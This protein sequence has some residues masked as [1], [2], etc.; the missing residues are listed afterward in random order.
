MST[1]YVER[2]DDLV[3]VTATAY[4]S[5]GVLQALLARHPRLISGDRG[6]EEQRWLL[7]RREA[8]LASSQDGGARWSVDHLFLDRTAVPTLV[9][10]KRSTDTRIRREVVGQM[11]DYA[12]NAVLYWP[13][14]SLIAEFEARCEQDGQD[15]Q[16]VMEEFIGVEG[17]IEAFWE[18]ARTNLQAGRIRLVFV[19]DEIPA[20]L[21]RIIEFMNLQMSP[22]EVI[23]VEVKRYEG[24]DVVM[25]VP[26]IVGKTAEAEQTKSATRTPVEPPT[27]DDYKET[28]PEPAYALARELYSRLE[29]AIAAG[30]RPLTPVLRRGYFGFQ[31][32]GEYHVVGVELRATS[33]C[34]LFAKIPDD[35][36]TLGLVNPYD[37]LADR[38]DAHNRQWTWEIPTLAD[39]P[40]VSQALAI[41]LRYQPES[42]AMPPPAAKA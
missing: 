27:W 10:V 20:E 3:P 19:A 7:I 21:L 4:S 9:E 40:D 29:A 34:R 18:Q 42:G 22:A 12:A 14:A 25:L 5:E 16:G 30:P 13:I 32:P 37:G 24:Q 8:P 31:R 6:P 38:W 15:P 41:S 36:K 17:D 2:G 28:L 39:V 26:R 1:I 23:G 33:P 11:L 35:P